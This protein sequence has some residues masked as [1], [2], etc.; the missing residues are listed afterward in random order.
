MT[1]WLLCLFLLRFLSRLFYVCSNIR[2]HC[3][4]MSINIEYDVETTSCFFCISR[5]SRYDLIFKARITCLI[6]RVDITCLFLFA[7]AIDIAQCVKFSSHII[8]AF[9]LNRIRFI[10]YQKHY[11]NLF[12]IYHSDSFYYL[13]EKRFCKF[14][15]VFFL[16]TLI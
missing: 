4:L 9:H 5:L 2:R 11:T 15:S 16:Y 13:S 6:S 8:D 14:R 1:S 3:V 12:Q 10:I 7:N